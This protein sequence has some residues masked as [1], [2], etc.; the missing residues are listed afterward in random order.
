MKVRISKAW[1]AFLQLKNIC[2][3]NNSLSLKIKIWNTSTNVKEVLLYGTE[4][5]R[6]TV[7]NT[8]KIKT[9]VNS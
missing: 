9:G 8:K 4:T 7:T 5:C 2:K 6:I 1:L 3:Y